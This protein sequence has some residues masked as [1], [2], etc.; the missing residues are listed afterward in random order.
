MS[1][2]RLAAL[3]LLALSCV[4]RGDPL[5][6]RAADRLPS[7]AEGPDAPAAGYRARE[8]ALRG[9][10]ARERGDLAEAERLLGAALEIDPRDVALLTEHAAALAAID[11]RAE[12]KKQLRL[13]LELDP[14]AEQAWLLLAVIEL[15]GGRI[16]AALEAARRAIRAEPRAVD[17]A[18]WL[19]SHLSEGGAGRS[20]EELLTGVLAQ[21][22]DSA[23]AHLALADVL[24]ARGDPAG[25]RRHLRRYAELAVAPGPEIAAR[26]RAAAG[27]DGSAGVLD[28]LEI[29]VAAGGA[30]PDLRLELARRLIADGRL[31]SARRR[32]RALPPVDPGDVAGL[33]ERAGLFLAAK[34]P[35]E[36]RRLLLEDPAAT[37]A[38]P[39][40]ARLLADIETALGREDAAKALSAAR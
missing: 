21:R 25:A 11:R 39:A 18:L 20:A 33:V 19:A 35:W 8:L 40:A 27:S 14:T 22:P 16:E 9:F 38:D 10:V 5:D 13:A 17:A 36:A 37:M 30:E 23:P 1:A 29:A 3:A 6:P 7:I 31:A 15:Q 2:V 28:I 24:L 4:H 26:A 32:L 34:A 12:A